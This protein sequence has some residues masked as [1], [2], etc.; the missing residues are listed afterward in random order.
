MVSISHM[1][2]ARGVDSV[3]NDTILPPSLDL[4][5]SDV[6]TTFEV[7]DGWGYVSGTNSFQDAEKAMR[8]PVEIS[9]SYYITEVW[10]LFAVS[11]M[12]GNGNLFA[13]VYTSSSQGPVNQVQLSDTVKVSGI[14]VSPTDL[15]VTIFP[16]DSM[17]LLSDTSFFA[18][19]DISGLYATQDTVAIFMTQ[20][21]CSS[22]LAS[23]DRYSD[24][25][26]VSVLDGWDLDTDY[27]IYAVAE[28][29]SL[30]DID[31]S[32]LRRGDLTV[33]PAFPNPAHQS[34]QVQFELSTPQSIEMAIY[35]R[36]GREVVRYSLGMYQPGKHQV[37]L[38]LSGIP[39]GSYIYGVESG[40]NRILSVFS[41]H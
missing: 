6:I 38:D 36:A 4:P 21:Q 1:D 33:Y 25:T 9:G 14:L 22:N 7:T 3:A 35:D 27:L 5:C 28:F 37:T 24:G 40:F 29:Q 32:F 19:I 30:T 23:W 16:F 12:V 41:H 31:E 15:P 20:D 26:W 10:G 13:K 18:S 39:A 34:M 17:Q 2:A 11:Q 8:L